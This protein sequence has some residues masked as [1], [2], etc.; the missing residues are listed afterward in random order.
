MKPQSHRGVILFSSGLGVV[1]FLF[2][3]SG[4][5]QGTKVDT[6]MGHQ[7]T[8][9]LPTT[10]VNEKPTKSGEINNDDSNIDDSSV[11]TKTIYDKNGITPTPAGNPY[12]TSEHRGRI[13]YG[14]KKEKMVIT[15][16]KSQGIKKTK[17]G[18]SD[19]SE[20]TGAFKGS[21]LD[22]PIPASGMTLSPAH[23]SPN[24]TPRRSEKP[25]DVDA[26]AATP[27]STPHPVLQAT[28]AGSGTS[29]ASRFSLSLDASPLPSATA[30][31]RP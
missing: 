9:D 2:T 16:S 26:A 22:A 1:L 13:N 19:A 24:A 15:E 3:N 23:G 31:P 29:S 18:S 11:E 25:A 8:P 20:S 5:G 14:K 21:L 27:Q 30:T 17:D 7:T 10:S 12:A 6:D 4:T 28:P